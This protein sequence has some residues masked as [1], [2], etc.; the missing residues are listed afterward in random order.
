MASFS[1]LERL[2]GTMYDTLLDQ[3]KLEIIQLRL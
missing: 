3:T 2:K 1:K